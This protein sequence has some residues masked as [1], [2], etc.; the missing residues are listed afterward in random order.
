TEGGRNFE[1]YKVWRSESE[2][3]NPQTFALLAQY[4]VDDEL[5]FGYQTGI[6]HT[7]IDTIDHTTKSYW[8]A[9]TSYT[10]PEGFIVSSPDSFG[11]THYD[12][13]FTESYESNLQANA[14]KINI[15]F[16]TSTEFGKVKVVPNPYRGD[17]FYTEGMGYEGYE[18]NW[19]PERRAIWFIHLPKYA[20]IR[21]YSIVGEIITTIRHND[22]ERI[23]HGLPPGQEEFRLFASS[24]RP[25]ASGIYVFTVDSEFGQQIGKFVIIK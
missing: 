4:D 18:F 3:F 13:L 7:F 21:V 9:I 8:Y 5:G 17:V 11:V 16:E 15:S 1:G 14:T 23:A 24:G 25:L 22:D 10:I 19:T 20:T 12:T 6:K 2:S